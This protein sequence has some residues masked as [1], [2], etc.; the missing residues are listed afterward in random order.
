MNLFVYAIA[1]FYQCRDYKFDYNIKL[2]DIPVNDIQINNNIYLD[3][4]I[5]A[6]NVNVVNGLVDKYITNYTTRYDVINE[7]IKFCNTCNSTIMSKPRKCVKIKMKTFTTN[8]NDMFSLNAKQTKEIV[9]ME[10]QF[11]QYH[12]DCIFIPFEL[13]AGNIRIGALN[14]YTQSFICNQ[15]NATCSMYVN[16]SVLDCPTE[17]N[18]IGKV[19]DV[20]KIETAFVECHAVN[21]QPI[22]SDKK[23]NKPIVPV[24]KY[25]DIKIGDKNEVKFL[26]AMCYNDMPYTYSK[27]KLFTKLRSADI[28]TFKCVDNKFKLCKQYCWP[29]KNLLNSDGRKYLS[30]YVHLD[31]KIDKK[32]IYV[33]VVY[34]N[35]RVITRSG[36]IIQNIP[37]ND[38][39]MNTIILE[40]D[41]NE[42][43]PICVKK[44]QYN[45]KLL[46]ALYGCI[47]AFVVIILGCCCKSRICK[48]FKKKAGDKL[49]KD[50][51]T[52]SKV[53]EPEIMRIQSTAFVTNTEKTRLVN[54]ITTQV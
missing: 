50:I 38:I 37:T 44:E 13:Y 32:I 3:A 35:I 7:K 51:T 41:D 42:I 16:P 18:T 33:E 17:F 6:T 45:Q 1:I 2:P 29:C 10:L 36:T 26:Y 46:D 53:V 19:I 25:S 49:D 8:I 23:L 11:K 30:K 14:K 9:Y 47:P 4:I 27:S 5:C 12:R 20:E 48:R 40:E 22:Y 24:I 43:L 15:N 52:E 31:Q 39:K 34:N 28:S 21:D 54:S